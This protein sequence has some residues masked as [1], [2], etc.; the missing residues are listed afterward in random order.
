MSSVTPLNPDI[1][2]LPERWAACSV[3]RDGARHVQT[4]EALALAR[5]VEISLARNRATAELTCAAREWGAHLPSPSAVVSAVASLR[6]AVTSLPGVTPLHEV[7]PLHVVTATDSD[8]V[9]VGN[10]LS[11]GGV[12]PTGGVVPG[13]VVVPAGVLKVLDRVLSEAIEGVSS[14]LREAALIDPLTGCANRRALE[15]IWSALSPAPTEPVSTSL[16]R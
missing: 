13:D 11:A 14:S 7:P 3:G 2:S 1:P 10:A 16:W 15:R 8:V 9:P 12:V 5:A 6:E 4:N